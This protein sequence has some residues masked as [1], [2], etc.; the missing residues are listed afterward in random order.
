MRERECHG[1]DSHG[2]RTE[3]QAP[4]VYMVA[5]HWLVVDFC[6]MAG[7]HHSGAHCKDFRR[8]KAKTQADQEESVRLPELRKS[9]EYLIFKQKRPPALEHRGPRKG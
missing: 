7:F 3:R 9:V 6:Q 5:V 4:R 8:E 1:S 2:I